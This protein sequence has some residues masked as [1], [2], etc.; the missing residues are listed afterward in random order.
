[1]P[2]NQSFNSTTSYTIPADVATMQISLYGAGGGGEYV[3]P[4]NLA[5]TPGQSGGSTS[6]LGITAFGGQGGGAAFGK[7]SPGGGGGVDFGGYPGGS[8]FIG[9]SG[10]FYFGGTG[11]GSRGNGGNGTPGFFE[12]FSSSFHVFDNNTNSFIFTVTSS[13]ISIDYLN[14]FASDQIFGIA[15]SNGKYYRVR[16]NQPYVDSSYTLEITFVSQQ[17][18]GGNTENGPY[19]INAIR[20]KSANGFDIWFQTGT[21]GNTYIRRFDVRTRGLKQGAQGRGGGAGGNANITL[22]RDQLISR[23]YSPG[24]T[25]T[26]TVGSGGGGGGSDT[27]GG[28]NGFASLVMFIKPVVTLTTSKTFLIT[29]QCAR[30]TW[31]TT[32]DASS[33]TWL[34]G[35]VTNRNLS[36]FADV[37]PTVTTTYTVIA[38]G[39]G[40]TSDPATVTIVVASPPTASISSGATLNYGEQHFISYTTQYANISVKI[41]PFYRFKDLS[42]GNFF[43]SQGTV[44][45]LPTAS[46]ASEGQPGT[47]ASNSAYPTSIPYDERGPYSVQYLI[48]A[49]GS[50]G[51]ASATSDTIIIIDESPENVIIPETEGV[52]KSQNPVFTPETEVLSQLIAINDVDVPVEIKSSSPIQVDINQSGNWRD[53]RSI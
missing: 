7:G 40:G 36:S 13:D 10:S 51:S 19:T 22:S 6:W 38:S 11:V 8:G 50:G 53:L 39:A 48:V 4:F 27:T 52:F 49:T 35:N 16:F 12:Y 9:A 44:V 14:P 31:S 32:G 21:G 25:Y 3:N 28:S 17:A 2:I 29:G 15:P 45:N 30:L 20:N 24:A 34:S 47:I 1:M 5:S 23:G 33:V 43:I 26:L 37:C 42:T 18:A 41:T 46:N